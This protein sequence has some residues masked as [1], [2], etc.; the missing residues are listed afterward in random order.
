MNY[1]CFTLDLKNLFLELLPNYIG[2]THDE[3]GTKIKSDKTPVGDLDNHSLRILRNLIQKHFPNDFVLGEEDQ[4]N[5]IE[6]QKIL[7]REGESQWSIDGLDGTGNYRMR[8]NSYCAMLARRQGNHILYAAIFRPIDQLLR[9]DGFFFADYGNGAWQW[10]EEHQIYH[11]LQTAKTNTDRI[12]VM[13]EGSSKRLFRSP[14]PELGKIIT[15]RSG[16]S[17]GI[18]ATTV[19]QSKASALV[20]VDNKPWDTW[21]AL[22][23][24]QEAGGIVTNW[25][26]NPCL[27]QNCGSMIAA[28]NLAVHTTILKFFQ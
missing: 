28:A 22:L 27:P 10:C 4:R 17:S 13:L 23:F 20:T 2:K 11:K 5:D 7:L 8:T 18:A 21:P 19:A 14:I 9:G 1:E 26:G 25:Q 24:I 16:F 15:T 3:L 6:I 12:T